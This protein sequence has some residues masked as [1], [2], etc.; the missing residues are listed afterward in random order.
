[1]ALIFLSGL[2]WCFC[3]GTCVGR[4]ML[5]G[6][7]LVKFSRD[8]TDNRQWQQVPQQDEEDSWDLQDWNQDNRN[9][10]E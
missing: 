7:G 9:T 5:R 10:H 2:C 4:S 6:T 3:C 8:G 1:M